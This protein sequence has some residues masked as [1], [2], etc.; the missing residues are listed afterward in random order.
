MNLD[1]LDILIKIHILNQKGTIFVD[2]FDA[3]ELY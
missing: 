3:Y 1:L 2:C